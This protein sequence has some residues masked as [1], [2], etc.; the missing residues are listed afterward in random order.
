MEKTN[1]A[2][3]IDEI[4]ARLLDNFEDSDDFDFEGDV[5]NVEDQP[6]KPSHVNFWKSTV[7]KWH[8]KAMKG[9][10]SKMFP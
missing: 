6:W 1:I 7:K 4:H 3:I 9:N 2:K 8:I 10:I 5:D